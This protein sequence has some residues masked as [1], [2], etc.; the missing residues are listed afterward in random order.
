MKKYKCISEMQV[1]KCD[2]NGFIIE[3][4]YFYVEKGSIWEWDNEFRHDENMIRLD[5]VSE[6]NIYSWIEIP[7]DTLEECFE[8]I[9][10]IKEITEIEANNIIRTRE[11]K[12][13]FWCKEKEYYIAIDNLTGD[14][15]TENFLSKEQCFE[16]LNESVPYHLQCFSPD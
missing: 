9:K 1:E 14:S 8:E 10:I 7:K 4:E 12:G 11:P 5:K 2:D 13:L 15:W 3:N 16:Y 6:K